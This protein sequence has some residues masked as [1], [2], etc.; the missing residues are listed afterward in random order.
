MKNF[1]PP[2]AKK[3]SVKYGMMHTVYNN[4]AQLANLMGDMKNSIHY[5]RKSLKAVEDPE[6]IKRLVPYAET[7][8]NLANGWAYLENVKP[9]LKCAKKALGF[10]RMKCKYYRE[11]I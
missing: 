7:Y 8:L 10:S 1:L 2:T 9:A 3:L 11:K 6:T 4:L 5:L